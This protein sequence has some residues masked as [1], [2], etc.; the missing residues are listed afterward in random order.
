MQYTQDFDEKFPLRDHGAIPGQN[1]TGAFQQIQPYVKSIQLLQCP[2]ETTGAPTDTNSNGSLADENGFSDYLYNVNLQRST[3]ADYTPATLSF[4]QNPT[5]T[6]LAADNATGTSRNTVSGAAV[7][8]AAGDATTYL[9]QYGNTASRRHLDGT[10]IVFADGH[11]KWY[12]GANSNTENVNAA[13][14]HRNVDFEES[15]VNT[16]VNTMNKPTFHVND[17]VTLN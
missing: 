6:I 17:S 2:S 7:G 3:A 10:A 13:V 15:G 9:T 11:A 1:L 8:G 14:V 4:V 16:L 12:K 5:L